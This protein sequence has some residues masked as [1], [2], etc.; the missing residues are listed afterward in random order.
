MYNLT[1]NGRP[2]GTYTAAEIAEYVG[3][4]PQTIRNYAYSGKPFR[5]IF[6][7]SEVREKKGS[8]EVIKLLEGWD[9][10]RKQML[11]S[12]YDLSRIPVTRKED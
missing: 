9:K 8:K 10:L 1:E 12:G 7:F 11:D 3:C 6:K 5:R 2:V 4:R